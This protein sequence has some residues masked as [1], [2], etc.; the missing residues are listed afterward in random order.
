MNEALQRSKAEHLTDEENKELKKLYRTVVKQLHPDINP[1]ISEAQARLFDNAVTAYKNGDLVFLRL[2]QEMVGEPKAQPE[3]Q[4]VMSV[5]REE[6]NRL[7]K[8]RSSIED[9]ISEIKSSY[10][11]TVK[12]IVEQPQKEAE[13]RAELQT[14]LEQ[15]NEA[16]GCY[17]VK[18]A[19]MLR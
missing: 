2:I 3:S 14:I 6:N 7:E 9:S 12:E 16:I 19:E 18:L 1:D 8:M 13:R 15:Y 17:S 4:D 5:L 10:P 11:Y